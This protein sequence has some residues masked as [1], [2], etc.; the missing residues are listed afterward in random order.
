M[1]KFVSPF[2]E[3]IVAYAPKGIQGYKVERPDFSLNPP[4]RYL[5][6]KFNTV[7]LKVNTR[8]FT[9]FAIELKC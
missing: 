7:C 3:I 8:V 9:S 6:K 4:Y 5:I 1:A 2:V